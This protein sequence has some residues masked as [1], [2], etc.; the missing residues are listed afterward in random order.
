MPRFSALIL[1]LF[2]GQ[3]LSAST[4][5][6]PSPVFSQ[7]IVIASLPVALDTSNPLRRRVGALAYLGGWSLTSDARAF[8]GLSAIDVDGNRVTALS[9]VG[10]VV[11]FRFGRFGNVSDA[12]LSRVPAG[13]GAVVVKE[14]NDTESL[15]HDATRKSWWIGMEWRN[16]IC[17]ANGDFT[18]ARHVRPRDMADW[19]KKR[20]AETLLRLGD[21]RFLAIAEG[22]VDDGTLR[23]VVLFDRDPAADGV[24]T[25]NFAYQPPEG[26]SP[27]DAAQLPDGRVLVLN[28]RFALRSLF[29]N[30]LVVLD[31]L[32]AAAGSVINGR[33]IARFEPPVTTDNFEG[34]SVTTEHGRTIL[35]IV[36]D[37]N[38]MRWQ[39]TLLL[40]FALD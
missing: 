6:A 16:F 2:L 26:F 14:D 22:S 40:K 24:R 13:C 34:L 10:A 31:P 37:N 17:R 28:R 1:L 38:Y 7:R 21:G 35:W 23:P 8:G 11:R 32:P 18:Q 25:T 33:E 30:V 9:D 5:G 4:P 36:S 20:G 19:P 12:D 15:T 3:C 27:T 29:T 39:R